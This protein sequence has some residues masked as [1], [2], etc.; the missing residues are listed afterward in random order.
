MSVILGANNEAQARKRL[1]AIDRVVSDMGF[2]GSTPMRKTRAAY[3]GEAIQ[4]YSYS[5]YF[6]MVLVTT[7]VEDVS[8]T[9]LYICDG[10][11]WNPETET[12]GNSIAYINNINFSIPLY[13]VDATTLFTGSGLFAMDTKLCLKFTYDSVNKVFTPSFQKFLYSESIPSDTD[14]ILYYL[15]GR[16]I[17]KGQ[18]IDGSTVY[19]YSLSQDHLTGVPRLLWYS[20][21]S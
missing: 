20:S 18:T 11:T 21:C 5:S 2:I 16:V 12:S 4:P 8:I 9:M 14:T 1:D 13:V 3:G 17:R 10:A 6:T 7:P 19:S 15:I